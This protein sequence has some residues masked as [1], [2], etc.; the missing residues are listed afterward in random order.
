MVDSL[1]NL[2]KRQKTLH[3]ITLN[4]IEKEKTINS[5]YLA[6]L[7]LLREEIAKKNSTISPSQCNVLQVDDNNGKIA[8][9]TF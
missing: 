9:I 6:L 5:E 7:V 4:Y 3:C 2:P 8:Q 1:L